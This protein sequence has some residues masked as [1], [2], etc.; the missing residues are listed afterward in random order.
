[1][2][3][4]IGVKINSLKLRIE[5]GHMLVEEGFRYIKVIVSSNTEFGTYSKS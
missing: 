3:R 1:M 2:K 5:A 4:K